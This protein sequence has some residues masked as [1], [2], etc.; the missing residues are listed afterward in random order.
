MPTIG[1]EEPFRISVDDWY[2][3]TERLEQYITANSITEGEQF[4]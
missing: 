3:Y 2:Q 1:R 4:F